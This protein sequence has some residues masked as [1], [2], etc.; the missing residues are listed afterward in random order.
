A[1]QR[2]LIRPGAD[3]SSAFNPWPI[4]YGAVYS[5]EPPLLDYAAQQYAV[6]D[7]P[8]AAMGVARDKGDPFDYS[9]GDYTYSTTDGTITLH[10]GQA[11]GR[12]TIDMSSVGGQQLDPPVDLLNG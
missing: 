4:V 3:P 11:Q 9:A 7:G 8:I 10:N 12:V 1:L 2:R 5:I 6:N